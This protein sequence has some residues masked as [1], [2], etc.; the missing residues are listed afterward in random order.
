MLERPNLTDEKIIAC[1]HQH[2][3][4]TIGAFE[5]LPIG[6]DAATWV[7]RATGDGGKLYFVKLRKGKPYEPSV[8][9]PRYLKDS[10][11][12]QI[13][14]PLP[15]QTGALW[16]GLDG[17]T[18]FVYPFV[19]GRSG[20][21]AGLTDEQWVEYGAAVQRIHA[22]TLPSTL[23]QQLPQETFVPQPRWCGVVKR[24]QAE[25][26]HQEYDSPAEKELASFWQARHDEIGRIV[27]RAEELGRLLQERPANFVLCHADI[28]VANL[29]LDEN[30]RLFVIDWD[31][32]MLAPKERDLVYILGAS[33]G[34]VVTG[35]REE[36]LFFQGYRNTEVDHLALTYYRYEWVVQD[37][38]SYAEQALFNQEVSEASKQ[39]A[40]EGLFVL[41]RPG[42][43][44]EGAYRS[45]E[46]LRPS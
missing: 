34:K 27:A 2:Y 46:S 22:T 14:E 40:V 36:E 7:Y 6:N 31:Q 17:F 43:S 8:V 3:G 12:A 42:S 39:D 1:L 37:L 15:T 10:G 33:I 23:A 35:P 5:F 45:E 4:L 11:M 24:L 16:Q 9:I 30:G 18:L 28:H 13:I 19:N 38:G 44:V 20:M 41:F 32:P 29:L 21:T 25:I 26:H